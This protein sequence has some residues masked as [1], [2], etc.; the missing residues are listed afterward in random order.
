MGEGDS[1]AETRYNLIMSDKEKNEASAVAFQAAR[2]LSA[3]RLARRRTYPYLEAE[4]QKLSVNA[5]IQLQHMLQ[6]LE[7]EKNIEVQRAKRTPW[8]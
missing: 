5:L 8:R 1:L 7:S 6:N 2:T 4:L 3:M